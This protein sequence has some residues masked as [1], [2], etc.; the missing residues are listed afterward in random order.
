MKAEELPFTEACARGLLSYQRSGVYGLI[1]PTRGNLIAYVGQSVNV[2]RRYWDHIFSDRCGLSSLGHAPRLAILEW[3]AKKELTKRESYWIKK[4]KKTGQAW[5]NGNQ[6]LSVVP[7]SSII[8]AE[9]CE[10]AFTA[11][12]IEREEQQLSRVPTSIAKAWNKYLEKRARLEEI[13]FED[14]VQEEVTKLMN[15]TATRR[16]NAALHGL[17]AELPR[18]VRGRN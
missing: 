9:E 13:D 8:H 14:R 10:T 3:C 5:L 2:A 16:R 1:D 6:N 18:R 12:C 17:T 11:Y 4:M 15:D 7:A